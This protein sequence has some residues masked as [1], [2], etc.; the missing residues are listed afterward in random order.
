MN[1]T[2]KTRLIK[3][4]LD[5]NAKEKENLKVYDVYYRFKDPSTGK[6]KQ[7]SKKGFR[8]KGEA[9]NFLL[10]INTQLNDSTFIQSKKITVREYLEEWLRTYVECN[11]KK[12]TISSYKSIILLHIIPALGNIELQKLT[13]SHIDE[14]YICKLKNGRIDGKGGLSQKSLMYIHRILSEALQHAVKKKLL[15]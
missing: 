13:S 3:K 6:W 12:K 15:I 10:R 1:G 2:I 8:S 5:K 4:G 14:F 7:T 9:E 11:L